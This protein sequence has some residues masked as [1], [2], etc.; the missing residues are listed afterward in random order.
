MVSA[1]VICAWVCAALVL[2]GILGKIIMQRFRNHHKKHVLEQGELLV[3]GTGETI[4]NKPLKRS[5]ALMVRSEEAALVYFD[6]NEPPCPPCASSEPDELEWDVFEH[7]LQHPHECEDEHVGKI[8][9]RIK[10][11][12]N[13]AR[14][15][16]WCIFETN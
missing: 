14:T 1:I 2:A 10:W 13:C 6:E 5:R 4:I 7:Q 8:Y 12:V 16:K 3:T 9:L 15:I 11:H